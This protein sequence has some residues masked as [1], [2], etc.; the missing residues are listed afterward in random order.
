MFTINLR[1]SSLKYQFNNL[2]ASLVFSTVIASMVQGVIACYFFGIFWAIFVCMGVGCNDCFA[3]FVGRSFG[4]TPL[5][6]LSPNKTLEGFLGGAFFTVIWT[7]LNVKLAFG[8]EW[9][10]CTVDKLQFEPFAPI[11]CYP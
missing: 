3:Y 1:K 8:Y 5:I 6:S 10:I 9:I 2:A 11:S 4:R 7:F